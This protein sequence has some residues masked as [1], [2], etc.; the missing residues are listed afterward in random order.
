M[1]FYRLEYKA[2]KAIQTRK[3]GICCLE[4]D[5]IIECEDLAAINSITWKKLGVALYI[6]GVREG[7]IILYASV[8]HS[9]I[10]AE[11]GL[12]A[13]LQ[14]YMD[15]ISLSGNAVGAL[16]E[17]TMFEFECNLLHAA[18][19]GFI[20]TIRQELSMLA[21]NPISRSVFKNSEEMTSAFYCKE[22]AIQKAT[23]HLCANSLLS[24]INR[25]CMP[26][27]P[28]R[29]LGHPVHY[30]LSAGSSVAA[31][32]LREPLLG[33][34]LA[35]GRLQSRRVCIIDFS[36]IDE[37]IGFGDL[38]E[39]LTSMDGCT[40]VYQIGAPN[41][42]SEYADSRQEIVDWIVESIRKSRRNILHIIELIGMTKKYAEELAEQLCGITVVQLRED[43]A[44]HDDACRYLRQLA[45]E[46][47]AANCES[48]CE[49]LHA[50]EEKSYTST[51]LDRIFDAWYD[52]YLRT[53]VFAQYTSLSQAA[54]NKAV[55]K[56]EGALAELNA[57]IGLAQTKRII[58]EIIDF[59]KAQKLFSEK[60]FSTKRPAMHMAFYGNPGTAKTTVARLVAQIMKD[61]CL[62]S[63][64]NL[65]EVGRSN[66]VGKYVG[67]TAPTVKK[68][69]Q[70]AK[71]SV[72]FIDEAYS[73]V[74]ERDGLYG[75]EAI[76]T[77]V[78]EMENAREDT[79][80]IFAGYPD[81]MRAFIEKNPG[82]RSR[83][84]FHVDFPDYNATELMDILRLMMGKKQLQLDKNA[85]TK[86]YSIFASAVGSENFGNGRFVRNLLERA[87]L[88][89]ATRLM[90]LDPN[91]ITAHEISTL[92][93][94]DFSVPQQCIAP[95]KRTIGF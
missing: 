50:E 19:S 35:N 47:E 88:A 55:K 4:E 65:V 74:D 52:N 51:E 30:I 42:D 62:L 29:F 57:M 12:S 46:H 13:A 69:F 14:A 33:A 27:T 61:S 90:R 60:G 59:H 56:K 22:E 41:T 45:K 94:E 5:R 6:S 92:L 21:L 79:V 54:S 87:L 86:I 58:L 91:E 68:C 2:E 43:A 3:G 64:G 73:L 36:L 53:E 15:G 23:Q 71:G 7:N 70:Q 32:R 18:R 72:L 83:I 77:I 31:E 1:L 81:K 38:N 16:N 11:G 40:M 78:Q 80:V 26:G 89:Q 85:E 76:N 9:A 93:A 20:D 10:K 44:P 39:L 84:A 8:K 48:L 34:L 95:L 49:E 37:H 82:L 67:W 28:T 66:L 25:I 17:V 24:E 63:E 75:D